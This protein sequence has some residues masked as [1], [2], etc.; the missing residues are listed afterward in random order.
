[1]KVSKIK[2]IS[3][4][5]PED[6]YDLEIEDNHNFYA[7]GILVHNCRLIAKSDG[8][9]SRQGK[10]FYSVPHI[11]QALEPLFAKYPQIVLDGELYNHKL[12]NDFNRI[13]SLARQSKPTQ[14]DLD[15]SA[16]DLKYYVYD[17]PS[18]YP[19]AERN[20]ALRRIIEDLNDPRIVYLN[21][22]CI[23]SQ[24]DLDFIYAKYIEDGYE[25]QIVRL[26][27]AVYEN[28]RSK[29]LLKRKTFQDG[30]FEILH[31]YEGEG[32][33]SGMAGGIKYKII[34]DG[35]DDDFDSGIQGT[36]DYYK[37]IWKDREQYI[38]GQ[39]TVKFFRYSEYGKPIFPVTTALFKGKRDI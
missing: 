18:E 13:M 17:L 22:V 31:I 34:I 36:F 7:N 26:S 10:P 3:K 16:K 20:Q 32:N 11:Y 12:K 9:F 6:R 35:K 28:K 33:R 15:A 21:T 19:F 1:M 39:G 29:Q 25:G 2:S 27:N 5:Q 4:I 24:E 14:E 30:E 38:G 37:E 8:L 23:E